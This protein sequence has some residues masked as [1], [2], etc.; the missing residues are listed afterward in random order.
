MITLSLELV[1]F[2]VSER[3][4]P[5]LDAL[6][7]AELDERSSLRILTDLRKQ[8]SPAEAAAILDQA[9]L[10]QKAREK[11]PRAGEMLF[12]DEAL[13]QASSRE[14]AAYHAEKFAG[15][16]RMADLGSGIGG[17]AIAFASMTTS[18]WV[19]EKNPLLC[20]M[21][22]HNLAVNG[23]R[24]SVRIICDDWRKVDLSEREAVF[25]DPARRRE[26]KRVFNLAE[27]EPSISA[28]LKLHQMQANIAVKVAPGIA[29]EEIPPMA[30]T[31]FIS[32]KSTLK[33]A[34]LLF[35]GLRSGDV[36]TATILPGKH[37]MVHTGVEPQVPT[38]EPLQYI[39]EPDPAVIRASLVRA[40]AID[41]GACQ[42][43]PSIAY[44]TS[45]HLIATPF[46]RAWQVMRHGPFNL[47]NLNHWLREMNAGEVVVKKRGSPI[48]PDAFRKRLKTARDGKPV[49]VFITRYA[50][51][52]WM[53]ITVQ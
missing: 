24:E 25:I 14:I 50:G 51:K 48:E 19:I 6:F 27:M 46:A 34:L 41:L 45:D 3:A 33:E 17:D 13:Q 39:Y 29:H 26:G 21:L 22:E 16:E 47:K 18:L 44:L 1:N 4:K 15:Y 53:L 49:T 8:F 2:L 52:P 9:S 32:E 11:F 43:D 36:R 5:A 38:S 28:V 31:E 12:T 7:A 30:E 42:L 10:R 20:R 40:L 23:C 35:G 37:Q